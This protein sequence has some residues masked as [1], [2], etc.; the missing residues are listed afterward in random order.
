MYPISHVTGTPRSHAL[1]C[2]QKKASISTHAPRSPIEFTNAGTPRLL[3]R[4]PA[5][6]NVAK[7]QIQ[8]PTS[9]GSGCRAGHPA[10]FPVEHVFCWSIS[11]NFLLEHPPPP[12]RIS[13]AAGILRE[14]RGV[15]RVLRQLFFLLVP[16]IMWRSDYFLLMTFVACEN[17]E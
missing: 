14:K 8:N 17:G 11:P 6:Q 13:G 15:W 1:P 10:R 5:F 16:A 2:Q 4:S 12:T 3:I 7:E 9:F